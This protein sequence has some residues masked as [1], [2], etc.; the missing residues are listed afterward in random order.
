MNVFVSQL[1]PIPP[2][3]EDNVIR[4]VRHGLA[5]VLEWLGEDVGPKPGEQ[6]HVIKAGSQLLVSQEFLDT[7][8]STTRRHPADAGDA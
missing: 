3:A 5:D 2:S 6:I 4:T 7:L 8:L 1:L